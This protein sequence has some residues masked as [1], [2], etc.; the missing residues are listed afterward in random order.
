M[1]ADRNSFDAANNFADL[2]AEKG[3][4]LDEAVGRLK[5]RL[6]TAGAHRAYGLD[7]LGWLYHLTGDNA[8]A[9]ETLQSGLVDPS[10]KD[11][12]RIMIHQHLAVVYQAMGKSAEA[13]FQQAEA[14]R[15]EKHP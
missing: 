6:A 11:P 8:K 4:H 7:T 3:V 1:N 5:P 12:L 15:I 9:V 14:A 13:A 10:A 2:C